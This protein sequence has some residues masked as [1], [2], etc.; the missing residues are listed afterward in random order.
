MMKKVSVNN[1]AVKMKG[2]LTPN[3]GDWTRKTREGRKNNL[4]DGMTI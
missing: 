1:S 3:R 2:E 4:L